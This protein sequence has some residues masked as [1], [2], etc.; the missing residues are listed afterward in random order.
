MKPRR[1]ARSAA[2][3]G[4]SMLLVT[5][6][7]VATAD[8]AAA[9]PVATWYCSALYS[10]TSP[11]TSGMAS[12]SQCSGQGSG[13]GFLADSSDTPRYWC[14]QFTPYGAGSGLYDVYGT[15][16]TAYEDS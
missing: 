8:S 5:G 6:S 12:G 7:L 10:S 1:L 9:D 15:N 4:V 14:T 2:L 11:L 3:T 13:P 16:C